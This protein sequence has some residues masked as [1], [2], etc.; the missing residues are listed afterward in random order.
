MEDTVRIT[1]AAVA[2]EAVMELVATG[3]MERTGSPT[4]EQVMQAVMELA[5]EE[6]MEEVTEVGMVNYK[7]NK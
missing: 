3:R 5:T 6:A 2:E 4:E 1:E 7:F